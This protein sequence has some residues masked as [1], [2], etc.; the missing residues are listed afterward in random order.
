MAP[1]DILEKAGFTDDP[2]NLPDSIIIQGLTRSEMFT[3][4]KRFKFKA[5]IQRT[6]FTDSTNFWMYITGF[7]NFVDDAYGIEFYTKD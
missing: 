6:H 3:L 4:H 7:Y 2:N 1:F 5:M